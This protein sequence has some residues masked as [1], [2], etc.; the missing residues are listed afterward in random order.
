MYVCFWG[1]V[2]SCRG[3]TRLIEFPCPGPI[4]KY[5]WTGTP[6]KDNN[7]HEVSFRGSIDTWDE[8]YF[9]LFSNMKGL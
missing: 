9:V 2:L 3:P 8:Q 6:E 7:K 1:Q 4:I 5:D